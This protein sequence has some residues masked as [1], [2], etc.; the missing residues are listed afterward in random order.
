M[1]QENKRIEAP[2]KVC[3]NDK[4]FDR[5]IEGK[6]DEDGILSSYTID[7]FI[8]TITN[9]LNNDNL[10]EGNACENTCTAKLIYAKKYAKKKGVYTTLHNVLDDEKPY[11]GINEEDYKK[12]QGYFTKNK[13][14]Q[15]CEH[16]NI[17]RIKNPCF[18]DLWLVIEDC[19]GIS[20]KSKTLIDTHVE[21]LESRI[22]VS[23]E[24]SF[25]QKI[26]GF[27]RE[28]YAA[29]SEKVAPIKRKNDESVDAKNKKDPHTALKDLK[30]GIND[31]L[32]ILSDALN[33][34][35]F[36]VYSFFDFA[37]FWQIK[38]SL[39]SKQD[40]DILFNYSTFLN[41]QRINGHDSLEIKCGEKSDPKEFNNRKTLLEEGIHTRE[42]NDYENRCIFTRTDCEPIDWT[43]FNAYIFKRETEK[44]TLPMAI[45]V[46]TQ[47]T[48]ENSK[49]W[50]KFIA[51]NSAK[52][53]A[54]T[55]LFNALEP[56]VYEFLLA[57]HMLYG[58]ML[59]EEL[60]IRLDT[61]RHELG[62]KLSG[63]NGLT[64]NITRNSNKISRLLLD[65]GTTKNDL[66]KEINEQV[67]PLIRDSEKVHSY[68]ALIKHYINSQSVLWEKIYNPR[69]ETFWPYSG[70]ILSWA[71][72][73]SREMRES[74]FMDLHFVSNPT[75]DD[76]RRYPQMFADPGLIGMVVYNLLYN[77]L[78]YSYRFT[79]AKFDC[80]FDHTN[81]E[82]IIQTTN[83]GLEAPE[84]SED[85]TGINIYLQGVRSKNAETSQEE[86][87]LG[88]GL[89]LIREIAT[90][91]GG[92]VFHKS[93]KILDHNPAFANYAR[94]VKDIYT[95]GKSDIVVNEG[96]RMTGDRLK[97]FFNDHE[98][99]INNA[100]AA[101]IEYE[102]NG[103]SFKKL[104]EDMAIPLHSSPKV[105]VSPFSAITGL[106][107]PIYKNVF[108]FKIPSKGAE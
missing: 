70:I 83:Y 31:A 65:F 87:G 14:D 7:G 92:E 94:Y 105:I 97:R 60:I 10:G 46:E 4:N 104:I 45:L 80:Y 56:I 15:Y 89:F 19:E 88:M 23:L 95:S 67:K 90:A 29:F 53:N 69:K 106:S 47:T 50:R 62:Q 100:V 73:Y 72:Y 77:A 61:S 25:M 108:T 84:P 44:K 6:L 3:F 32:E 27:Q 93:E 54:D 33:L 64:D 78:K 22:A 37:D 76:Y 59:H 16:L 5:S 63:L 58:D 43:K 40:D 2:T 39:M 66:M 79:K 34:K 30:E 82:Y 12:T 103:T 81:Q 102:E 11:T 26:R 49:V 99:H 8:E 48:Y 17:W 57:L 9:I 71:N 36:R 91:H 18:H 28:A 42:I 35:P 38:D 101:I 86:K 20:G 41:D 74:K 85:G 21:R 96:F 24:N 13:K 107:K 75:K 51:P 55:A 68:T 52:Q 98:D 1:S